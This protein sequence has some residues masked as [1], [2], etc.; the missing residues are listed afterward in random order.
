M[1]PK[2]TQ[3]RKVWDDKD[4]QAILNHATRTSDR[5]ERQADFDELHR[6]FIA[7]APMVMLY[8]SVSVSAVSRRVQGYTTWATSQPRLWEV[9]VAP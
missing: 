7:A 2:D 5:A 1:G 8:N 4:A 3:P 9:S 6:R